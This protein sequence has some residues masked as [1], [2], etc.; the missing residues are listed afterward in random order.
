MSQLSGLIDALEARFLQHVEGGRLGRDVAE[1]IG[2]ALA[3]V[4]MAPGAAPA[5]VDPAQAPIGSIEK[6]IDGA[7]AEL[8]DKLAEVFKVFEARQVDAVSALRAELDAVKLKLPG[9]VITANPLPAPAAAPDPQPAPAAPAAPAPQGPQPT[10][11]APVAPQ[12]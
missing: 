2:N 3:D 11:A 1:A 7:K 9:A 6:L 10:A 8:T 12:A 4:G 5:A